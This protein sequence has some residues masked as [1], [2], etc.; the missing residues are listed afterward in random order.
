[1]WDRLP[2]CLWGMTGFWPP[3]SG[4]EVSG[5]ALAAG[6]LSDTNTLNFKKDLNAFSAESIRILKGHPQRDK[7]AASA[8]PL[9][10][11]ALAVR[12]ASWGMTGWKPIP[13]IA[14]PATAESES[15]FGIP[16]RSA[17]EPM[18]DR[19]GGLHRA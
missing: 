3:C 5:K 14:R 16:C 13:L 1:M 6:G 4:V 2:A 18:P 19:N 7:P 10:K 8:L 12:V 9:I 17:V 15:S 11:F